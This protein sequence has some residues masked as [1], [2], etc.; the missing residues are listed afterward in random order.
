M[1][2]I[3]CRPKRPASG[4]LPF[5]ASVC[6]AISLW[7]C[8]F[9]ARANV[10]P[11]NLRLNGGTTNATLAYG[12][13][14]AIG[15]LLNEPATAGVAVHI[16]SGATTIRTLT[17]AGGG[18]GTARGTNSVTW[19][20][21]DNAS[22][23]VPAGAYTIHVTTAANGHGDWT[24]I[25]NDLDPGRYVYE[26][27]GI[28]VNQNSNSLYYG[29][30]FVGNATNGPNYLFDPGDM[31]GIQKL[32][33]DGSY[34]DEGGFSDG[35]WPWAGDYFSPWK[36]EVSADDYVY[37]NDW[38]GNGIVLRFD[39]TLSPASQLV[40][41][42]DDN[43]PNSGTANLSGPF[44]TGTGAN[45]KVWMADI[46]VSPGGVGIRRWSV[47]GSG[48]VET[49][50]LGAT[51][52]QNGG[53]S[54][55]NVYPYDVAVDRSNR[56][57]TIQFRVNSG[58]VSYRVLRFPAYNESGTAQTNADWRI[59]TADDSMRGAFGVAVNPVGSYLAVA[60]RGA[61]TS[62]NRVGCSV[63][64]FSTDDG[65]LVTT[66][67]PA[68]NHDHTDVAWDN[69][70]NL[71]VLDNFASV[72]R[73]YSPPGSNAATTIAPMTVQVAPPPAPPTLTAPGYSAGQFQ[74]T[75]NGQANVTYV[76]EASTN[77][78]DWSPVTT[79]TSASA[80]RPI[81]VSAP[82]VRSYYRAKLAP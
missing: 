82:N 41:L 36:I 65:S 51:I 66:Q 5:I 17:L 48:I 75:L 74:F 50:D 49:N 26:P 44:I 34:A 43:W 19:N 80:I 60:F 69:V 40:V 37:V 70:G 42:R 22:N 23:T 56:I 7:G 54:H 32:N 8:S 11:T 46:N 1:N 63:K 72:W 13:A 57:Y 18:P 77:L 30:V 31:V 53:G 45:T 47:N 14:A 16:K 28:A 67:T 58:D 24:Q 62:P 55:L 12:G 15:Y 79:N 39:Q 33:A 10:Y 59:G 68:A 64:V 21:R 9:P 38:T 29:R 27:R 35:G 2:L 71:Y 52:V 78:S 81:A 76:I 4:C 20:G 25:S 6:L 73:V 3:T 61:G